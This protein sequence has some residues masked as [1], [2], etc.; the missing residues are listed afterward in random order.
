[1]DLPS[2]TKRLSDGV[3]A[4]RNE[5]AASILVPS[6]VTDGLDQVGDGI[7]QLDA[8]LHTASDAQ[9]KLADGSDRLSA[10]TTLTQGV[11]ALGN[12]I[13]TAVIK[14]PEDRKLSSLGDGAGE[15]LSGT[16][17]LAAGNKKGENWERND[18]T[19]ALSCWRNHFSSHRA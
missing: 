13:H 18:C 8:G 1:M 4:F 5:T 11:Q 14:L 10:G 19:M 15:L 16:T 7:G 17:A 12:G 6:R 9:K 2:G 3:T